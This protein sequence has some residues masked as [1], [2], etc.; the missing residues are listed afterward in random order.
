MMA[1]LRNMLPIERMAIVDIAP[2][3]YPISPNGQIGKYLNF[4]EE[5]QTSKKFKSLEELERGLFQLESVQTCFLLCR[6]P[7]LFNF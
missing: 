4:M 3:R 6:I 5:A 7:G 1:A 2:R